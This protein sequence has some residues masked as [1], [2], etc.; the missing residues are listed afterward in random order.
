MNHEKWQ[1]FRN[2]FQISRVIFLVLFRKIKKNSHLSRCVIIADDWDRP[3][4]ASAFFLLP[5]TEKLPTCPPNATP[6][7]LRMETNKGGMKEKR[8]AQRGATRRVEP[9]R[10]LMNVCKYLAAKY[11]RRSMQSGTICPLRAAGQRLEQ[12]IWGPQISVL[13]SQSG[14]YSLWQEVM[15]CGWG[16]AARQFGSI[17]CLERERELERER[18]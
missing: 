9:T 6:R 16:L 10:T 7:A 4:A 17:A 13:R 3:H 8:H 1:K 11:S 15:F 2:P 14:K 5:P 18:K 12:D